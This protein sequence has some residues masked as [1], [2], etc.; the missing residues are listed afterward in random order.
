M[1]LIQPPLMVTGGTHPARALRMMVRDLSHGAQGITEGGDL[2]VAPTST[3]GPGVRVGSGS[4]V[5]AGA[6]WGQGSYTQANSG[7]HVV[8]IAPTGGT[9]RTDLLVLRVE[10][11]EFE[12]NRDP[13]RDDIGYLH[14]IPGVSATT[15]APP[16]G[17]TAIPLARITLP[18]NCATVTAA[19]ITDLRKVANPR[20]DRSLQ[21]I[22]GFPYSVLPPASGVWQT[23]WPPDARVYTDVPIWAT[24]ANVVATFTGVRV[25]GETFFGV[26][27]KWSDGWLSNE[28][29]VDMD[30]TTFASR[31]TVMVADSP[32]LDPSFRGKK[33]ELRL[34]AG[35]YNDAKGNADVDR[36]T[37]ITFD[38]EFIE[39]AY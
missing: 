23:N 33:Q 16:S 4:A 2:K 14:V 5:I 12:G 9:G 25:F 28:Y 24:R 17:M 8:P 32:Y 13:A 26:R 10:D 6:T 3:P 35:R 30:T 21:Q 27:L 37:A 1:T 29:Q 19:M 11:P 22:I 7:D 18:A 15:T 38:V 31:T 34:Q 39:S 36:S 20:R